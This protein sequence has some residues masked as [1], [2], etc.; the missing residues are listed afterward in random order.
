M[1]TSGIDIRGAIPTAGL[2]DG[3]VTVADGVITSVEPAG[4]GTTADTVIL[5]GLIDIHC[6]GGGGHTFATTDPAEAL[7]AAAYHASAGTTG[8]VASLVTAAPADL[9]RQL[10]ALK[11]LVAAGQLLGLH[12]EG[13]FLAPRRRGAHAPELLCDPDPA[14]VAGL[15]EAAGSALVIVTLAPERPGAAQAAAM[16]RAAGVVV[17]FGHT[18]ADYACM[19]E[20][21]AAA[22]GTGLVTH[23]GNAMPPLHHRAAGPVAAALVAAAADEA[24]VELIADGV[25][26]DAGFTR[27]VFAT[28]APGR[29]VLVTDAT[30][31]AGMPDGDYML[32][33]LPVTVSGGVARLASGTGSIAGGTSTLLRVVAAARA[34]GV[35]L[36][37]AARA[38][39][40]APARV[41]GLA[42]S[43]G[44]LAPGMAADL[45]VADANLA[46]RRVMRAGHWL[47]LPA[48]QDTVPERAHHRSARWRRLTPGCGR[49]IRRTRSGGRSRPLP[50]PGPAPRTSRGCG[51]STLAR[52]RAFSPSC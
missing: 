7:A 47:E 46:L 43:R 14:L 26:V 42:G 28:A 39:S 22:G 13:P 20:A 34:A 25:H 6:H 4:R 35:P 45:V 49:G 52:G 3:V 5:P 23:L 9:L 30:A 2:A 38:A 12:L 17:A 11:P 37:D 31:A 1:A 16:L 36:A 33:P 29:V 21:L 50:P 51:W 27:L 15:L 24:S 18:D 44:S 32:G 48:W 19:A 10:R 41:L 8:V 40:E